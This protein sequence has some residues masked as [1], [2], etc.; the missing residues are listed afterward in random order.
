MSIVI[1]IVKQPVCCI[2]VDSC[3][4]KI[5]DFTR[6]QLNEYFYDVNKIHLFGNF[7]IAEC[8]N[9]RAFAEYWKL[10]ERMRIA[11]GGIE[12]FADRSREILKTVGAKWHRNYCAR[13]PTMRPERVRIYSRT[14]AVM[15]G[16]NHREK[17]MVVRTVSDDPAMC[18]ALPENGFVVAGGTTDT[19]SGTHD[20]LEGL[21]TGRKK[22]AA[23]TQTMLRA[24]VMAAR[25]AAK[26]EY[27]ETGA[28]SIG[29]RIS[30]MVI[31]GDQPP[32]VV[33]EPVEK[34]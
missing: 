34:I 9:P 2:S 31:D 23:N 28:K 21:L 4:T 24:S 1:A 5:F 7:L 8:G 13:W 6:P 12:Y 3:Q 20:Y 10:A 27:R 22:M 25:H 33:V 26:L 15:A 17:R 11:S 30:Q 16:W 32:V 18:G 14:I 29:G 19:Q